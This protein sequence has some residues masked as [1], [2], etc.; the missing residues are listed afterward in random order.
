MKINKFTKKIVSEKLGNEVE[1]I[2]LAQLNLIKSNNEIVPFGYEIGLKYYKSEIYSDHIYGEGAKWGINDV[3]DDVGKIINKFEDNCSKKFDINQIGEIL[4]AIKIK[5]ALHINNLN[6]RS[7]NKWELIK[8]EEG[9]E[10]ISKKYKYKD[11]YQKIYD[12]CL[13]DSFALRK[14]RQ[15]CK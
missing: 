12:K 10:D 6:G 2:N 5:Y 1:L 15:I 3:M 14:I 13:S 9:V 8:I 11:N 4:K 7:L